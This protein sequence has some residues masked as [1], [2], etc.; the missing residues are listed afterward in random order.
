MIKILTFYK[1]VCIILLMSKK[2]EE[3]YLAEVI[4]KAKNGN[5][6]AISQLL[7][8]YRPLMMKAVS[9]SYPGLYEHGYTKE[10][11]LQEAS[12][13]LAKAVQGYDFSRNVTFGAYTK[14]CVRNRF[15]SIARA[16]HKK[17][18]SP[19]ALSDRRADTVPYVDAE[20]I[21]ALESRLTAYE[22]QVWRLYAE[23]YKPSEIAHTLGKNV[24]SIYN[25][26][27]RIKAKVSF[28]DND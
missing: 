11:L 10:D 12:F 18:S 23:G 9:Y 7:E 15:A 26:I 25:A 8:E 3:R 6:E 20:W 13:A 17:R 4:K 28:S 24:K 16:V 5:E 2:M 19:S 21:D 22:L 14:R 1:N 27:C